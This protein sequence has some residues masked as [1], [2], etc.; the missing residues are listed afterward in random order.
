M[1][2][3]G[4]AIVAWYQAGTLWA[5][6]YEVGVGWEAPVAVDTAGAFEALGSEI[7][8]DAAGNAVVVWERSNGTL[9]N[10]A[11][12]RYAMG[13]W[14]PASVVAAHAAKFTLAGNPSGDAVVVWSDSEGSLGSI[15]AN[16]YTAG[17]GWSGEAPL[18]GSANPA[19]SPDVGM[20]DGGNAIAVWEQVD[21]VPTGSKTSIW[22]S[23]C[24]VGVGWASAA[25]I[26]TLTT[27]M[28]APTIA[29][30][31]GGDAVAMWPGWSNHYEV[32]AGWG[33]AASLTE[34]G[35][36]TDIVAA[37]LGTFIAIGAS[38]GDWM[39]SRRNV[40]GTGWEPGTA[41]EDGPGG[42]PHPEDEEGCTAPPRIAATSTGGAV[43][44]WVR[45][46]DWTA[47]IW[48]NRYTVGTGWAT[49][50]LAE[51]EP[52]SDAC[53]PA[54]AIDAAGNAIVVWEQ[55]GSIWANRIEAP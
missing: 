20:D 46:D 33:T 37:D 6:R 21:T 22:A 15:F 12:S 40:V 48:T 36:P 54:V 31:A 41:I 10:L 27:A 49:A 9:R 3:M 25:R 53:S 4:N 17:A 23:H 26:E 18:E 44:V 38:G 47:S 39:W 7:T 2:S 45:Y 13:A 16:R 28:V 35:F 29:V 24:L 11:S 19:R 34:V 8:M 14:E 50:R 5:S 51:T 42:G 55:S 30:N 43:A 1:E 32:G 52:W